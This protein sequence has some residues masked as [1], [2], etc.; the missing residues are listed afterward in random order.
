[1][2]GCLFDTLQL[3]NLPNFAISPGI[4]MPH[5]RFQ[6]ALSLFLLGKIPVR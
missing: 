6:C 1:M 2:R 5:K 4:S 3:I